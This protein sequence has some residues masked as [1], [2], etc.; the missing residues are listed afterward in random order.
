MEKMEEDGKN[1]VVDGG[2]LGSRIGEM[3]GQVGHLKSN[4]D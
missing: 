4:R 3:E 1:E 2:C